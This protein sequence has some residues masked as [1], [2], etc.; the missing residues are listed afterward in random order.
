LLNLQVEQAAVAFGTIALLI[1][2]L[3]TSFQAGGETRYA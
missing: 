2:L 1:A 3:W